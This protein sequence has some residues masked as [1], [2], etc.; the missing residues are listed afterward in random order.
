LPKSTVHLSI[1]TMANC[2]LRRSLNKPALVFARS[3]VMGNTATKSSLFS[4]SLLTPA[5][6]PQI[7]SN[8]VRQF[9]VSPVRNSSGGNHVTLWNA[10]RA[11]SLAL[12][13]VM[14]VGLMYP[15]QLGDT[16]MAVSIVMH[17]H[18]GLEAIVTDYVRPIMFG[19]TVPKM[20]HGLLLIVSAAT[21]G[22]LFYFNY[23]DIGIAGCVR[24]IWTTKAKE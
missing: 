3:I 22:G 12:L 21:L 6:K 17:Q 24:K 15:S 5:S 8:T 11:L 4:A 18:W 2:I 14:P 13:G 9:A 16:L 7:F 1:S 23:N 19:T 20:A 10:E